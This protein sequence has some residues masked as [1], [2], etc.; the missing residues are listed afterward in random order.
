[1]TNLASSRLSRRGLLGAG[2]ALALGAVLAACGG[3]SGDAK[4]ADGGAWSFTDDRGQKAEAKTRPRRVVAYVGAAAALWDFGVT[5]RIVGVYGP[6]KRKDGSRDP[7]VGDVDVSKVEV[8]GNAYGEFN[9]EK[10]AALRPELL[11]DHMFVKPNLFY[12]PAESKDKIFKLAP[13]VGIQ[14][15]DT[16]LTTPIEHYAALATALDADL[17]SP[18][19]LAAK[20]RFDKAVAS[21]R[22]AVAA[23]KGVKVLAASA[24]PDLF[25]AS[26]PAKNADLQFFRQLGVEVIVPS[27]IDQTGY[28][29]SLSWENAGKYKADVILL[30]A[31]TQALQPKDLG[32][33]PS[34][35]NLPAVKA[36]QVFGWDPEPRFSYAGCAPIIERLAETIK[37]ARKVA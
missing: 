3:T 29:E 30:D 14:A 33:K 27:K 8:I 11:V 6:A 28:F 5:D 26:S 4:G 22:Q 9:I 17:R 37:N 15:G 18:T 16:T 31:R 35:G 25:Y 34:W 13:S 12:V 23:N 36:N 2:G 10:Y 32:S 21:L 1:M 24:S 7:Q 19:N 20:D